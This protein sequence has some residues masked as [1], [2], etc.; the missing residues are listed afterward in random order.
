MSTF[1][2]NFLWGGATA[3][4]QLEGG[5]N[6]DGKG[7][8]TADMVKFVPKNISKG[9]NTEVVSYQTVDEILHG[10]HKNEYYPKREGSHFYEHYK[11]D[12]ALMAEMGFKCFRMSISWPRIYPTGEEKVPNEEGL[13]FYDNV[14]NELLK[15][16]IEP[17]VTLSH[18]ETPLNLALKYNGWQSRELIDLFIKYA[19]TCLTRYKDKVKY[20]IAFNEINMSLNVPY[21][22]AAI[23][24]E[25]T[26]NPNSATFQALHHQF[27]ASALVK[28]IS[29]KINPNFKIGSMVGMSLF[30]PYTN[31]PKDVL[32]TQNANRINYF[33]FDVL[34]KGIYPSYAKNYFRK[35][36]INIKIECDDLEII[37]KNTVDFNSFSYYYS[38]CT[39][40][41]INKKDK[42]LAFLPEQKRYDEFHPEKIRNNSL[43]ITDWG[44]QIDPIGLRIAINE[45]WDRY[46][47][48]I[49]ITENGLGTYDI[50]TSDK[51]IHDDYRIKYL[52][53]HIDQIG[54]CIDEGIPVIGYTSWGCIDIVSAG[55]SERSKRYGYIYVDADDYGQGTW[56]RYKKDSFYWYKKV[57]ESNGNVL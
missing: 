42:I 27:V 12:I 4:N 30:Y 20:W 43:E 48:P 33:F 16:N 5:Y 7:L 35:N 49:F 39:G 46:R 14:F 44:F 47:K 3:A 9:K 32:L 41:K 1:P 28:K 8:S 54:K 45:I 37:N 19:K 55:T 29:K 17:L 11:E 51:K 13:K 25:K 2:K 36:K 34:S 52:K 24:I 15:Y 21:S 10:L 38:N 22:G 57:I 53:E 50:L 40:E 26:C 31:S 56:K 6:L 18:Y 23:F